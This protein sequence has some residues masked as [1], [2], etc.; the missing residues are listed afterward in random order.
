MY[1][2][3]VN[4]IRVHSAKK[5]INEG[6]VRNTQILPLSKFSD[7]IVIILINYLPPPLIYALNFL[8]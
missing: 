7:S 5:D 3:N 2:H 8:I 1:L 6:H 4:C